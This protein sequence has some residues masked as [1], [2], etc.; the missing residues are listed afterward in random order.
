LDYRVGKSLIVKEAQ[1]I[2][3]LGSAKLQVRLLVLPTMFEKEKIGNHKLPT[4]FSALP[5]IA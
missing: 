5:G 3:K 4:C 2:K 1:Y